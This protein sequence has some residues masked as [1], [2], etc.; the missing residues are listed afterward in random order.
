VTIRTV[1]TGMGVLTPIGNRVEDFWKNL[2]E[3]RCGVGEVT[4]FDCSGLPS[5]I[6]A[7][8]KNF[9]ASDHFSEKLVRQTDRFIQLGMVASDMAIRESG[10]NMDEEDPYRTGVVFGTTAGGVLSVIDAQTKFI[11][12]SKTR[13]SPHFMPRM[14]PNLVASQVAIRHGMRGSSITI[15]TACASG[16]DAVGVGTNLLRSGDADVIVAGATESL[17]CLLVFAGLCAAKAMSTRNG[18]PGTASRPFDLNRDGFV[19][20]EGSGAVVLE[21]LDHARKR[22]APILA[23]VLGYANCG[24]GFHVM[25]PRPDGEGE[26]YCMRRTLSKAGIRPED[27]DYINAHGTSTPLGDKVETLAIKQVFGRGAY[28]IPVSSIKGAT[29]HLIAAAGITELVACVK[30]IQEGIIPPTINLTDPD[31]ECDLDYV[32][33]HARRMPVRTILS[34]SFGFGGQNASL[35]LRRFED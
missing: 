15:S 35:V 20:G 27:V 5:K 19:M 25:A 13:V 24:D 10:L 6:G 8:V 31:P 30:I 17:Y 14:L 16:T 21:T 7:E 9:S 1:V 33:N 34:N 11:T 2:I 28:E 18:K 32:P 3:G 12:N 26:A 4:H 22:N 23:E 29:G